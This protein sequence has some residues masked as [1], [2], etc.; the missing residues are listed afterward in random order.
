SK[1]DY[2]VYQEQRQWLHQLASLPQSR[3]VCTRSRR[4]IQPR[5]KGEIIMDA[6]DIIELIEYFRKLQNNE[7]EFQI[8]ELRGYIDIRFEELYDRLTEYIDSNHPL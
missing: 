7:L 8:E 5:A 2:Q 3:N 1:Q 6:Q 4:N